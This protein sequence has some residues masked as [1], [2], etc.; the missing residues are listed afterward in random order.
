MVQT[1]EAGV[2]SREDFLRLGAVRPCVYA[3]Q[4]NLGEEI[5]DAEGR[6]KGQWGCE[7]LKATR[8]VGSSTQMEG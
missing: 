4:N 1:L 6:E 7:V 5:D 2:Q 3:G 8:G